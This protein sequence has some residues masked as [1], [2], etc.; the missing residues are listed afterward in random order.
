MEFNLHVSRLRIRSEHA[1]GFLKGR[2]PSLRGLRLQINNAN[3]HRIATYWIAVCIAVHMFAFR[4][5]REERGEDD[6]DYLDPFVEEGATTSSSSAAS[7]PE[8]P[9]SDSNS[10]YVHGQR[11]GG[12][13]RF[14]SEAKR[15][16]STLKYKLLRA[17]ARRRRARR[18]M[19][20]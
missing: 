1:I 16:R 7:A 18:R 5:E 12:R 8:D 2:F 11:A 20:M 10:D 9:D 19:G 3:M 13:S 15:F 6:E 17:Q 4:V 14:L